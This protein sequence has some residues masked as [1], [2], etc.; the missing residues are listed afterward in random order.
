MPVVRLFG[1]LH[2]A[3]K[4]GMDDTMNHSGNQIPFVRV[5]T[6]WRDCGNGYRSDRV[7][8]RRRAW[9]MVSVG[10][11][12]GLAVDTCFFVVSLLAVLRG[13]LHSGG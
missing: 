2:D 11:L 3:T 8:S 4:C 5:S 7:R 10:F 13:I 1:I 12:I 6:S 9:L